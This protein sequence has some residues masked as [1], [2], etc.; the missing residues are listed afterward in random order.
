MYVIV[1][2]KINEQRTV[3]NYVQE[4]DLIKCINSTAANRRNG[5]RSKKE[6]ENEDKP[7]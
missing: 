5:Q 3:I 6:K 4:K 2:E 1:S 7:K